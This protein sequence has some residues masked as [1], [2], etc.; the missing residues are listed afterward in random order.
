MNA[1]RHARRDEIGAGAPRDR[2]GAGMR[3]ITI[4]SEDERRAYETDA[5]TAY[6]AL[7]LAVVLPR[8]TEESQR[9]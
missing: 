4:S 6:R 3:L 7:P 2:G 1:H 8:S 5:L 9:S